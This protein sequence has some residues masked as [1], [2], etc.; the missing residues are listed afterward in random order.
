MINII[1]DIKQLWTQNAVSI[2]AINK[3]LSNAHSE[4]GNSSFHDVSEI[5]NKDRQSA[6]FWVQSEGC[7]SPSFGND[8]DVLSNWNDFVATVFNE[9]DVRL[10]SDID[11]V[12]VIKTIPKTRKSSK[13]KISD[14]KRKIKEKRKEDKQDKIHNSI[15][16]LKDDLNF[17]KNSKVNNPHKRIR[18]E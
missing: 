16:S 15:T 12:P 2:D 14:K 1:L 8:D 11:A 3:I 6:F 17:L 7:K 5:S 4:A 13:V 9:D 10:E 18:K